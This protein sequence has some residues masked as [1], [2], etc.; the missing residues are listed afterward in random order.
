MR[1]STVDGLKGDGQWRE[2]REFIEAYGQDLFHATQLQLG[3]V[4]TILHRG[5]G[6]YLDYLAEEV[7]PLHPIKLVDDLQQGKVERDDAIWCLETIYSIVVDKFDRFL[8]YNTTTTQSD[9]GEKFFSLLD[10]L[11]VET[12]YDREAWLMMPQI[13]AHEMLCRLNWADVAFVWEDGFRDGTSSIA[14]EHLQALERLERL[15]GM[16]LPTISDHLRQRFVKPMLVSRMLSRI[17]PALAETREGGSGQAFEALHHEISVYL[18]DSWGSGID[19]PAWIRQLQHEVDSV[20]HPDLGGRPGPE[21][22]LHLSATKIT[23][24]E[25][26]QQIRTWQVALGETQ[27]SRPSGN[28]RP[29][30]RRR[31][32]QG[33]GRKRRKK[34]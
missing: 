5:V 25:F 7:D 18:E 16:R 14:A 20:L 33:G 23:R 34:E 21:A 22:E 8:E 13:V 10:F 17:Q 24:S 15:H 2:I 4:R 26:A 9:Y 11:N 32:P 12:R 6:W 19:I 1:L 30:G 31:P 3:N 29:K 28:K 27:R